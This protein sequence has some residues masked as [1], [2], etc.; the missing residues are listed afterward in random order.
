MPSLQQFLDCNCTST[1]PMASLTQSAHDGKDSNS[2]S[3]A[4]RLKVRGRA[5]EVSAFELVSES[6]LWLVHKLFGV[7]ILR[8]CHSLPVYCG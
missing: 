5:M 3:I 1:F 4:Q 8:G 7:C 2:T 6:S